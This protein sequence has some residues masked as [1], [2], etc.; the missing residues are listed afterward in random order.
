ME[1]ASLVYAFLNNIRYPGMLFSV[2]CL[3]FPAYFSSQF[4]PRAAPSPVL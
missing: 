3:F 2:L 4:L 1:S